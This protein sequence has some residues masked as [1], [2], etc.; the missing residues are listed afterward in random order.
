[1][2]GTNRFLR[3]WRPLLLAAALG[4]AP[5]AAQAQAGPSW[6]EARA[7]PVLKDGAHDFDFEFGQWKAH[8]A[9]RLKPLTGS[10][11]WVDYDGLSVVHPLWGGKANVGELDVSGSAGRIEG[12]SLRLYDAAS[13][14]WKIRWANGADGALGEPM[15]GGFA[16]GQGLFYNQE[17]LGGRA[18]LVRFIFSR[19]TAASFR[20]EQ[21]FS[22]DGGTS[23]EVNWISDFTKLPDQAGK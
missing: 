10:Q 12:M 1:M 6:P 17:E 13:R 20:I 8:I 2:M 7:A 11:S 16:G 23:W 14:Q 5:S 3:H 21:S 9:R 19:M 18:I 4:A 22:D 15:V